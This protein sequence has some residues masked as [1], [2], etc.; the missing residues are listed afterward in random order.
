MLAEGDTIEIVSADGAFAT[1]NGVGSRIFPARSQ[2]R[3]VGAGHKK[4]APKALI[5]VVPK[6]D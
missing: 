2:A 4:P 6:T 1:F 3:K 5:S